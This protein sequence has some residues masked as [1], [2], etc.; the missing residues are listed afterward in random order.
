MLDGSEDRTVKESKIWD[1]D[2]WGW[3]LVGR[4]SVINTVKSWKVCLRR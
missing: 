4:Y 1:M 2:S 3:K